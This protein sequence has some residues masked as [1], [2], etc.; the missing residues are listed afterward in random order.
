ME[1]KLHS[2][3]TTTP[4]TRKYIQ[5]SEKSDSDLA[6]ELNISVDTVRRWRKRD[7]C[8]DKSHRPNTI[9]RALSHEQ[10]AIL[11]FLRVRLSLSLDELL[12]AAQLLVQQGISRASVS[13][14]LQN[15][16]Q[17]RLTKPD[18]KQPVGHLHLDVFPLPESISHKHG[19]LLAFSDPVSGFLAVAL[20]ERGEEQPL[21][22]L[23]GFLQQGLL[24]QVLSLTSRST[25]L[26]R[27]LAEKLQVP[28]HEV[29]PE[30]WQER[31]AS[32][33]WAQ[34]LEQL[35]NGERYDK[36]LG[37]GAVLLEF[38]DLLNHRIIRSRLKNLTPAAWLKA[39]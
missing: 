37:F 28:L 20:R 29:L 31:A 6:E 24:L 35:L 15:W 17:S 33:E 36:R 30:A 18:L 21:D 23:V 11:V 19:L 13:R 22:A 25:E 3:A 12:E 34:P 5:S 4:R 39:K 10:E 2:N 32:G 1:I 9:H 16:Q 14:M 7:D 8:Y 27:K 26:T 38:E